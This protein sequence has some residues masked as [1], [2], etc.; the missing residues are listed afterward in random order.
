MWGG[1]QGGSDQLVAVSSGARIGY[2]M[3][4]YMAVQPPE[5]AD[6]VSKTYREPRGRRTGLARIKELDDIVDDRMLSV[7]EQQERRSCKAI[8]EGEDWKVEMD[9]HQR[10][11]QLWLKE[12]GCKHVVCPPYRKWQEEVKPENQSPSRRSRIHETSSNG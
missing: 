2:R 7:E 4:D 12:G 3:T 1:F 10:S 6:S 9:W 11:W 8:L 5:T